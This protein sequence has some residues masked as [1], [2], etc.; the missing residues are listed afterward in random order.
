MNRA[1]R[2]C[3]ITIIL[4]STAA[5]DQLTKSV[6]KTELASSEP[7]S[8]LNNMLRFEYAE[9]RGAFLGIGEELPRPILP[10]F[11]S[12]LA[13]ALIII[14]ARLGMQ[15]QG[16]KL[17]TLMGLSLMAGGSIGNQIDRVINAGAVVDFMS[18]GIG[19]I[20]TGIFNLADIAIFTG[21]VVVSVGLSKK[22]SKTD[23]V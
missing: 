20:R 15:R 1:Y 11:S 21:A 19:Q 18:V 10:L 12:L 3:L 4:L 16:V 6:A 14:I 8:M 22:S 13:V 17:A 7:T 23:A 5:C 9:N 2:L